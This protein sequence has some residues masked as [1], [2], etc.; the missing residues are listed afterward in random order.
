MS[1]AASR[2]I[3]NAYYVLGLRPGVTRQQI[4]REGTKLL[5]MLELGMAAAQRYSTPIGVCERTPEQVRLAMAELRDP[6]K[7]VLHEVFALLEPV[8]VATKDAMEPRS[9]ALPWAQALAVFGWER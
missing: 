8:P 6:N 4:E 1:E 7:R 2:Y 3:D 5:G 9:A